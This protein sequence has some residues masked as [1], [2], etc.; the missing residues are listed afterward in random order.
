MIEYK[1]G[2]ILCEDAEALV[3]SVNCLGVMG[4]GAVASQFVGDVE[5]AG[6]GKPRGV[7]F[8]FFRW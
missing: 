6:G 1:R 8:A 3:N 5:C 7:V 4:H 2:N